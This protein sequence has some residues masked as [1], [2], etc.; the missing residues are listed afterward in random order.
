MKSRIYEGLRDH[1]SN[2][3]A[4]YCPRPSIALTE[5]D[6]FSDIISV[7]SSTSPESTVPADYEGGSG[8]TGST[9]CVIAWAMV[10]Q[11]FIYAWFHAH[12]ITFTIYQLNYTFVISSSLQ[13]HTFFLRFQTNDVL[14]QGWGKWLKSILYQIEIVYSIITAMRLA[15][16][17]KSFFAVSQIFV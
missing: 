12:I 16:R 9:Y 14:K 6:S 13:A 4:A 7:V 5:M 17:L 11:A 10:S 1:S 3:S 8:S 15:L 2:H